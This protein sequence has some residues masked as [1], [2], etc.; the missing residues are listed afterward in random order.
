MSESRFSRRSDWPRAGN[1][2]S[3]VFSSVRA[4]STCLDLT[5]SNPTRVDLAPVRFSLPSSSSYRPASLG[6]PVAREAVAAYYARRGVSVDP[7]RI[8][9]T[10]STSEAYG[11]VFRLLCNPQDEVLAPRPSYPLFD[12][13]TD[14]ADVKMRPYRLDYDGQWHLDRSSL[15]AGEPTRAVLV[16]SPNNPTGSIHDAPERDSIRSLGL[17][18]VSDEVFADFSSGFRDATWIDNGD[19]FSL[20]GLSKAAGLPQLKLS[21]VVLSGD[22]DFVREA[23]A[24]LEIIADT[25]LSVA[26]PVQEA[27]GDV[28]LAAEDWQ[29]RLTKRIVANRRTIERLLA[30]TPCTLRRS[31]GGWTSVIEL[32]RIDTDE[33][34]ALRLATQHG[35][36]VHPGYLFDMGADA[37]IVV[38]TIVQE[39]RLASGVERVLRAVGG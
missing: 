30:G 8:I 24:R 29:A 17:P 31:T 21:W 25:F 9:I 10:A 3:R 13:L 39:D 34:W 16:V 37:T 4:T 2:L 20:S 14:L 32:P 1:A 35:V 18:V 33:D 6:L 28:L 19:V 22:D 7:D 23:R 36:L 12:Y 27:V 15:R 26:T 5:V 11:F 38:S